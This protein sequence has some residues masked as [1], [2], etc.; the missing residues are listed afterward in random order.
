MQNKEYMRCINIIE[1]HELVY[2]HEKFRILV[3]QAQ[4]HTGS[5]GEAIATLET[6]LPQQE[7]FKIDAKS[8]GVEGSGFGSS[9]FNDL[10]DDEPKVPVFFYSIRDPQDQIQYSDYLCKVQQTD[11]SKKYLL[12]A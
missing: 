4:I 8:D 5:I 7:V 1:K 11:L 3:A 9:S 2:R 6:K 10:V 12:L